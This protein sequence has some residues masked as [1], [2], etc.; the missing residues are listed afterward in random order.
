MEI[1]FIHDLL[2]THLY[3][4]YDSLVNKDDKDLAEIKSIRADL[5]KAL[6]EEQLKLAD[7][8]KYLCDLREEYIEFQMQVRIL[9]YGVKI[10]MELQEFFDE[11][12]KP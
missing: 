10:G 11:H 7:K 9:N 4:Y 5:E 3:P 8:Y 2:S 6:S 1:S 12:F